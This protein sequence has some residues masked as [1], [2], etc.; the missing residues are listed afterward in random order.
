MK[1]T[2]TRNAIVRAETI[3]EDVTGDKLYIRVDPSTGSL[4]ITDED[5]NIV[6]AYAPGW[7]SAN[8]ES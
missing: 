5:G 8:R 2:V 6:A 7:L 3:T 1:V 4:Q